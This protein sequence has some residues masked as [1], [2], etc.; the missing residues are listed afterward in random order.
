M[1]KRSSATDY[2]PEQTSLKVQH[3]VRQ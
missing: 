3:G 2:T 1:A